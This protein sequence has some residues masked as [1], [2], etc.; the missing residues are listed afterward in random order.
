METILRQ[1]GVTLDVVAEI[2]GWGAITNYVAAGVGISFV[3]DLCLSRHERV[4]RTS[5]KGIIPQRKYGATT[6]RDGLLA[7]AAHRFLR[8]MVPEASERPGEP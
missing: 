7:L 5:I 4:W 2:D 6:R 3:P 1:R 8:M